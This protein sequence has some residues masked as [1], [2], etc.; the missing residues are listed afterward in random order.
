MFSSFLAC[1]VSGIAD[2]TSNRFVHD[3]GLS[4]GVERLDSTATKWLHE[5]GIGETP[6]QR[7]HGLCVIRSQ[8]LKNRERAEFYG[9]IEQTCRGRRAVEIMR[10]GLPHVNSSLASPTRSHEE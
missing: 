3:G 5:V 9:I 1:F 10:A 2:E 8:L 4:E 7:V 6:W